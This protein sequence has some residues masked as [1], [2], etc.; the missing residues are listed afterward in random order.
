MYMA[1]TKHINVRFHNIKYYLKNVHTFDNAI[2][3][4][5]KLIVSDK[6]KYS[7]NMLHISQY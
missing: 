1:M 6:F 3:I 2:D 4:L 5:I 7:L